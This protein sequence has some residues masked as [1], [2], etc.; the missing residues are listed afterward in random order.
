[1]KKYL[2]LV[3]VMN[4]MVSLQSCGRKAH[5]DPVEEADNI[6]AEIEGEEMPALAATEQITI[7]TVPPEMPVAEVETGVF[8]KPSTQAVQEALKNAGLYSGEIDGVIGPKTKR[9][10]REFQSMNNLS[11]DGKVGRKT[12]AK[13]KP[14]LTAAPATAPAAAAVY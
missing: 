14:Y 8:E 7:P 6:I 9:A 3:L 12:W 2:I 4:L 11:V 1:M 13:L 10:I 5:Q